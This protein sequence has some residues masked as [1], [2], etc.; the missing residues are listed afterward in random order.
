[1]GPHHLEIPKIFL[2]N[3]YSDWEDAAQRALKGKAVSTL[4]TKGDTEGIIR[5]IYESTSQHP[6]QQLRDLETPWSITQRSDHPDIREANKQILEDLEGGAS[7]IDL[8]LPSSPQ[9]RG[10]GVHLNTIDDIA[11]L[12]DGVH[13]DLIEI[14]LDSGRLGNA[15]TALFLEA[16]RRKDVLIG[17]PNLNGP[18]DVIGPCASTGKL[19][20]NVHSA[21]QHQINFIKTLIEQDIAIRAFRADGR[22]FHN[23]GATP[24]QELGIV[25][26]SL[27]YYMRLAEQANIPSSQLPQLVGAVLSA[28]A[29]QFTTLTKARA[30][31]LLWSSLL[32]HSGLEQDHLNLH[33]ESSW[34]MMTK[35][36]PWVNILRGT[37]AALSAGMGGADSVCTLPFTAALGLPTSFARRVAR[38]SQVIL[39]EESH[40]AQVS[41]PAAGSGLVETRTKELA[42]SAWNYFKQI[43]QAGGILEALKTGMLSRVIQEAD[44]LER[45]R[46]SVGK[47]I[48]TGTSAF[49]NIHE[50]PV[51]TV[52]VK[53]MVSLEYLKG[54]S[55]LDLKIDDANFKRLTQAFSEG[56]GLDTINLNSSTDSVEFCPPIPSFRIAE[57]FEIYRQKS[58]IYKARTGKAPKVFLATL[59]GVADH[60]ARATYA[61]NLYAS[62][63]IEA[64]PAEHYSS[65]DAMI[66][67]FNESEAQ[68]ACLCS[69]STI[70]QEQAKS[71]IEAFGKTEILRLTLAGKPSEL[72]STANASKLNGFIFTGCNILEELKACYTLLDR[73]DEYKLEARI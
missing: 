29:D 9:A 5:A 69:S 20:F 13:C 56:Q 73:S 54:S 65:L 49:P 28:D 3:T 31:R 12:F 39:L 52:D 6:P 4:D 17:S 62:G 36:D 23:G 26:A 48:I 64:T 67:S 37:V 57:P 33:M 72:E 7:S 32:K 55:T 8:V 40:I 18:I 35:Y 2:G 19:N 30:M 51:E 63:G 24:A 68:L 44:Q 42:D 66:D 58:D 47:Q 15:A 38:N 25:L 16:S 71:V 53:K 60:T 70:Y 14:R 45:Q 10:H 50:K 61:A 21:E 59:G 27:V 46:I 43:E 11:R 41:D 1:M 22:I 34:R